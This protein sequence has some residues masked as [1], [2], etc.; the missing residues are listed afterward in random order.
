MRELCMV[1]KKVAAAYPYQLG[2]FCH[3][4][5]VSAQAAFDLVLGWGGL[6]GT[7]HYGGACDL[8]WLLST[9]LAGSRVFA[10]RGWVL[11]RRPR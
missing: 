9:S 7:D 1:A 11:C 6:V 8:C 4:L 10:P 3:L 2:D 5:R